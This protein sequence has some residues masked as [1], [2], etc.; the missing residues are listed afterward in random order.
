M[1]IRI[2]E[3]A[4]SR[5]G[6]LEQ[7]ISFKPG[8]FNLVFGKNEKG[9]TCLVEFLVRSLFRNAK[10]WSLRDFKGTGRIMVEGLEG[11]VQSFSP[12]SSKKIE[13]FWEAGNAGLPADFSRLLVVKG[14]EADLARS[15]VDK[16][17]IAR[18]LSGVGLLDRILNPKV[19]SKTIQSAR[20]ENGIILGEAKG[21]IKDRNQIEEQLKWLDTLFDQIDKGYSGGL[22]KKLS[23]E[24]EAVEA[25]LGEL[26]KAKRHLAFLISEA[27][28]ALEKEK[29]AINEG[30]VK[31][32]RRKVFEYQQK[33]GDLK[34]WRIKQ[35]A[36]EKRSLYYEW[37]K[38]ARD[39]YNGILHE[40]KSASG[41]PWQISALVL[42]LASAALM[43]AGR[44]VWALI[45]LAL[46]LVCGVLYW[47]SARASVRIAV[48]SRE[49]E[50]LRHGFETRFDA[51]LS[52]QA[53]LD[54]MLGKIGPDFSESA[55][56]KKQIAEGEKD[57][58][59]LGGEI[60]SGFSRLSGKA[61]EPASW[62]TMLD[63]TEDGLKTLSEGITDKRVE[64]GKLKVNEGQYEKNDPGTHYN[65][66][67]E[68]ELTDRMKQIDT[69]LADIHKKLEDLKQKICHETKDDISISWPDLIGRLKTKRDEVSK[70]C[71]DRTA[72]MLA[73]IAVV[74]TAETL[75]K[76]ENAKIEAGL[77]SPMVKNLLKSMTRRYD[78]LSLD[79]ERLRAGDAYQE[80]D[81]SDLSTG[82]REQVLLALRVGFASMLS[83]RDKLFLVLDD[84]FQYSDWDRREGLVETAAGLA[85]QGWQIFYFTMD[86]HIRGLFDARG[87]EFGE[88]YVRVEL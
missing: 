86:D 2:V 47:L 67:R 40:Q 34:R 70:A 50:A 10:D 35:A 54:A 11:K 61:V 4:V 32:L 66:E 55:F 56:L 42:A 73:K 38:S 22:P 63:A 64:H 80:F 44:R 88:E 69:D 84:A 60:V 37:L 48:R 49:L 29:G 9:K 45:L 5:L 87:K 27:M 28:K 1:S 23:D 78:R 43:L 53:D 12:T 85:K 62:S 39:Q 68:K 75:R 59:S 76:D 77:G 41:T 82:A 13:D 15:G 8:L 6:P 25:E 18:F 19:I 65:E 52:N 31:E 81:F 71:R 46:A 7:G 36:A 21:E 16:T 17:A 33:T 20:L 51:T 26:S 14:A 30:Q 57:L 72:E 74:Q 83:K 24:R 58:E 79:G 3:I